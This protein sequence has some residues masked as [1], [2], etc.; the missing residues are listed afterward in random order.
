[1]RQTLITLAAIVCIMSIASI[2]RHETAS[3]VGIYDSDSQHIW[4]GVY[5]QFYVRVAEN[6][7]EYGADTLDPLLWYETISPF[8]T[9][10]YQQTIARL[11]EFLNTHAENLIAD[12]VK[13]ALFQRDLWSV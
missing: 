8:K 6:G 11:D 4:N 12:P 13:H 1:M 5:S 7:D 9:A 10:N 3:A 2:Y